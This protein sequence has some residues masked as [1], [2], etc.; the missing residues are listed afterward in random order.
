MV[1]VMVKNKINKLSSGVFITTILIIMLGLVSYSYGEP[2]K[3]LATEYEESGKVE[4]N[5]AFSDFMS[6]LIIAYNID[7]EYQGKDGIISNLANAGVGEMLKPLQDC[8]EHYRELLKNGDKVRRMASA[9][10]QVGV[11]IPGGLSNFIRW[12]REHAPR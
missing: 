10:K 4:C 11:E 3:G 5:I 9:M 7:L 6:Q 8:D 12:C 1:S 2:Q